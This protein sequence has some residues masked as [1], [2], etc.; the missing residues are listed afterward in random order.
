MRLLE[1]L[2]NPSLPAQITLCCWVTGCDQSDSPASGLHAHD[3]RPRA[4]RRR[5]GQGIQLS[6]G[7]QWR[8]LAGECTAESAGTRCSRQAR[9]RTDGQAGAACACGLDG[10][11]ASQRPPVHHWRGGRLAATAPSCWRA[12]QSGARA[13]F[14][15]GVR[16]S[17]SSTF[18]SALAL[19]CSVS[20]CAPA[21]PPQV[22][23]RLGHSPLTPGALAEKVHPP[24][25]PQV[26]ASLAALVTAAAGTTG[27]CAGSA[28]RPRAVQPP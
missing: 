6:S 26:P 14:S 18:A 25:P 2:S 4:G 10:A 20:S 1:N 22:R 24:A 16:R 19:P 21:G 3:S 13:S 15:S 11:L 9:G 7:A 17:S 23:Q 12:G 5:R 27:R 28:L 8:T